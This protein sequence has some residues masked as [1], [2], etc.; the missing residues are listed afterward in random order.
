M[1]LR[2][3]FPVTM[4]TLAAVSFSYGIWQHLAARSAQA[5]ADRRVAHIIEQV[6]GLAVSTS[7]KQNLYAAM[8]SDYPSAPTY[9]G[10]DFSGSFASPAAGDGCT[11]DGQRSVCAALRSGGADAATIRSVCGTCTPH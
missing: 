4:F 10:I 6:D 2:I 1:N 7:V 5:A 11:N 8:F 9:F 3:V